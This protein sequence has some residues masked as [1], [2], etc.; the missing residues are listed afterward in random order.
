MSPETMTSLTPLQATETALTRDRDQLRSAA[1]N[2]VLS[3]CTVLRSPVRQP[4]FAGDL[5][6]NGGLRTTT[7]TG[8]CMVS[9]RGGPTVLLGRV[10]IRNLRT[11]E[12]VDRFVFDP[13]FGHEKPAEAATR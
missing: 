7:P 12:R 4:V 6:M 13:V 3:L 9:L 11:S 1:G 10:E 5:V 8:A 2:V